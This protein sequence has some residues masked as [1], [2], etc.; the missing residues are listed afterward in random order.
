MFYGCA[1]VAELGKRY[2]KTGL[3]MMSDIGSKDIIIKK[4]I[5]S[6]WQS[7]QIDGSD[8]IVFKLPYGGGTLGYE[9]SFDTPLVDV[10][11]YFYEKVLEL[12]TVN[13]MRINKR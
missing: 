7:F 4:L 5:F 11:D 3:I 8:N 9:V 13:K 1:T 2:M 6:N 10:L 12:T